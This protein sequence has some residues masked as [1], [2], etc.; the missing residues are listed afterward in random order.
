MID[1]SIEVDNLDFDID[2]EFLENIV[3]EYSSKDIELSIVDNK[4]IHQINRDFRDIDKPTDVLSFPLDSDNL[5]T[6]GIPL[7]SIVVSN[8][9]IK[10][11][12]KEYGSSLEDEFKLLFIHGLL[13]LVGFDHEVDS[14]QMR[15]EEIKLI[16]KYSLP[17]SLIVR[18]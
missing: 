10:S 3:K 8:D 12:A 4:A 7:G 18:N 17:K 6:L 15:E 11:G 5:D 16:T 9:F 14:G 1:L 13:H 2:L